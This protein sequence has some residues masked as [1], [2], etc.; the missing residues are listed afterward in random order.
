M[1]CTLF[2]RLMAFCQ[3]WQ[4]IIVNLYQGIFSMSTSD[5]QVG[6]IATIKPVGKDDSKPTPQYFVL[7]ILIG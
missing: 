4:T 6:A 7:K 5:Y 3:K 2:F 1:N